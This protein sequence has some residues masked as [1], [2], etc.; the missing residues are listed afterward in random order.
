MPYKLGL[1]V[2]ALVV[3]LLLALALRATAFRRVHGRRRI[4]LSHLTTLLIAVPLAAFGLADGEP[5]RFG[6][7]ALIY[8][9]AV[10]IWLTL[11]LVRSR[12][13]PSA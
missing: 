11:D 9:P 12:Q 10:L 7:S 13:G 1:Y 4:V 6:R 8:V 2:G 5:P 3:T